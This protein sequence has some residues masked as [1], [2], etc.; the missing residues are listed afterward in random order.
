[1]LQRSRGGII[2]SCHG[3]DEDGPEGRPLRAGQR[4][5]LRGGGGARNVA[6]RARSLER[7]VG[8]NRSRAPSRTPWRLHG[9]RVARNPGADCPPCRRRLASLQ[10]PHAPR[11]RAHQGR[12]AGA[13]HRTRHVRRRRPA[14][15]RLCRVSR[16]PPR[17]VGRRHG[18][19][20]L[21]R[22]SRRARID[23]A[24]HRAGPLHAGRDRHPQ[25]PPPAAQ[26]R[27]RARA[28][29]RLQRL[30]ELRR[31]HCRDRRGRSA[32]RR[33]RTGA[34]RHARLRAPMSAALSRFAPAALRR[35]MS[36]RT[37]SLPR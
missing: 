27:R 11:A 4:A 1:M 36:R 19:G 32:G 7:G 5:F 33:P 8:R 22:G 12:L 24:A 28:E 2:F 21:R 26:G 17:R 35:P 3:W 29:D 14:P 37:A 10:S 6:R 34:A 13:D 16:T 20:A 9:H 31:R 25:P 15:R 18:P 30:P 23:R